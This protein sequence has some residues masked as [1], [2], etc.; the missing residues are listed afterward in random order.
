MN[1]QLLLVLGNEADTEIQSA[2]TSLGFDSTETRPGA[3]RQV[4]DTIN[5]SLNLRFGV[6]AADKIMSQALPLPTPLVPDKKIFYS[7]NL[8]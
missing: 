6:L 8:Y 2:L 3:L 5:A 7:L 1:Q 4:R